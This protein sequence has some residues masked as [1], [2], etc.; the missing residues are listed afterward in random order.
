MKTKKAKPEEKPLP[1]AILEV[2]SKPC[3]ILEWSYVGI[4]KKQMEFVKK[5]YPEGDPIRVHAEQ[6]PSHELLCEYYLNVPCNDTDI[7]LEGLPKSEQKLKRLKIPMYPGWNGKGSPGTRRS[8]SSPTAIHGDKIDTPYR[9]GAHMTWDAERLKLPMYVIAEGKVQEMRPERFAIVIDKKY[10][11][12]ED[13]D[14]K[15]LTLES[16]ASALMMNIETARKIESALLKEGYSEDR[17]WIDE[18][19]EMK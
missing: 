19:V 10:F 8:S 2:Y 6:N 1:P 17:V 11:Y 5:C 15:P 9:D 13:A 4:D 14:G 3:L 16:K 7:R 18:L 12:R